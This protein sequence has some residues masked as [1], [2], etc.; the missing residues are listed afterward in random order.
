V[1]TFSWNA[2]TNYTNT[3]VP[4]EGPANPSI[5][6]GG[7]TNYHDQLQKSYLGYTQPAG[8]LA[9]TELRNAVSVLAQHPNVA[10][11]MGKQLIQ[12]LV[13]SNPSPAYVARISAVWNSTRAQ[14]NHLAQVVR[15]ILLDPE[16][17]APRNPVMSR[18]GKLQE[19]VL[20]VTQFLRTLQ[21]NTDA[22]YLLNSRVTNMGQDPFNSPT[23]FNFYPADFVIPGT[24][25][26]GPTFGIFDATTY[27]ARVNF[28]YN[29]LF[30][31]CTPAPSTGAPT[32]NCAPDT[33]VVGSIGTKLDLS[34]LAGMYANPAALVDYASN[35]LL[36]QPLPAAWRTAIINAVSA[37]TLSA[38]PT[39]AQMYD[40]ARTAV[41]LIA[42]SPKYQVEH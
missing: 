30:S 20:F 6:C 2:P 40:R 11:F 1:S 21:A 17:R 16:A 35:M 27:F 39:N 15:A 18:F 12:H 9:D 34:I 25:L 4:C 42:L 41:Y 28:L 38:T 37:V 24:T 32:G 3:M 14:P 33:T 31:G 23:V 5:P 7:A 19:P 36:Y 8:S 13:T 10:P 29:I 26:A 22:V